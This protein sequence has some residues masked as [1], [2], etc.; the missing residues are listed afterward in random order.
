MAGENSHLLQEVP[1]ILDEGRDAGASE[2]FMT[3]A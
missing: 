1:D 2:V 3:R